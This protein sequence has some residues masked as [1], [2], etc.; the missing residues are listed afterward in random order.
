VT[1]RELDRIFNAVVAGLTRLG[2][3]LYGSRV[4]AVP[5]RK[6]GIVRTVP[7][8]L[9]EHRSRRYL[10][11]PRA[12]TRNGSRTCARRASASSASA[13]AASPDAE[14]VPALRAY[15]ARWWFEVGRFFALS[16]PAAPEDELARAAPAH[17]VFRID[18][19]AMRFWL[20][21]A[22]VDRVS[23]A[24]KRPAAAA[25]LP[26]LGEATSTGDRWSIS[27]RTGSRRPGELRTDRGGRRW[28]RFP[29]PMTYARSRHAPPRPAD[30]DH[31]HPRR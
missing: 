24:R 23:L 15:I 11:A 12:A 14:K 22:R 6:S 19:P 31:C 7:V 18:P 26:R 1:Q 28:R 29:R 27:E 20:L 21:R 5:G 16:G 8:N 30:P 13:R 10:V 17:P 4:L 25:S 3:R 2:I 9:L